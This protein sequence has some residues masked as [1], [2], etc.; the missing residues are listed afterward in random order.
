MLP[1]LTSFN[2]GTASASAD[3]PPTRPPTR[4]P[5]RPPVLGV[6]VVPI[7]KPTTGKKTKKKTEDPRATNIEPYLGKR[8]LSPQPPPAQRVKTEVKFIPGPNM[9]KFTPGPNI[10]MGPLPSQRQKAAAKRA[11]D[12]KIEKE[13]MRKRLNK[14]VQELQK[15]QDFFLR[16]S[17]DGLRKS[18]AN[19]REQR[20]QEKMEQEMER[21]I[22]RDI[23]LFVRPHTG[24]QKAKIIVRIIDSYMRRKTLPENIKGI[25]WI[26]DAYLNSETL[27]KKLEA[28]RTFQQQMFSSKAL[29]VA[30]Q[31]LLKYE[32]GRFTNFVEKFKKKMESNIKSKQEAQVL[33][34]A[35]K[36][37]TEEALPGA[38]D[39]KGM[40]R[41]IKGMWRDRVHSTWLTN[42]QK[43]LKEFKESV[44][45][46]RAS[47]T[48]TEPLKKAVNKLMQFSEEQAKERATERMTV[49]KSS[50]V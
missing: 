22:E 34:N 27:Y 48:T 2:V 47:P 4:S 29:R 35:I 15:Q 36:E 37:Y 11:K 16:K 50:L 28:L 12:A 33:V 40:W 38:K 5:T 25:R 7:T 17:E 8:Q 10:N 43:T 31:E 39:I 24:N 41:D 30:I 32:E 3:L 46:L 21:E 26:W 9:V 20:T 13:K 18:E 1:S 45:Q 49:G 19:L 6:P 44:E 23:M 42:Q 14:L